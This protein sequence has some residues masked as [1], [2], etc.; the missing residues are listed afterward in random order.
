MADPPRT[1]VLRLT[2][3]SVF[4]AVG[5]L[6]LTLGV[7]A[8]LA[9]SARVIGWILAAVVIAGLLYPTVQSLSR[10]VPRGVA[11][12]LVV[13]A[14][15]ALTI[16]I[17]Y[18]VVDDVVSQ[19][20]ELQTAVPRAARKLEHSHRFGKA[21][22]EIHLA[23]RAKVF[24]DELPERLR[25]GDVQEALRSAA[26]R[27]VAFLATGVMSIFFLM[28][29]ERLLRGA[30]RQLPA[31]RQAEATRI[32]LSVYRRSWR[33]VS[34]SLTMAVAAGLLAYVCAMVLDLPGK[35][36]LAL[37]MVLLDPIPLLGVLLGA[38]PLILLAA[39]TATWQGSV[40]VAVVLVAW[41]IFE[42]VELQPKVEARSLHV[43]PFIT[44]AV[45]MIGLELYGIGG[46]I[47]GLVLAVV[48]A[49]TLDEVVGHGPHS[50][51]PSVASSG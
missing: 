39:T 7:L 1:A 4:R 5:M 43:G 25:G 36:P 32:G 46:A 47:I 18:A 33:Y 34:G 8:V 27:G 12:G 17:G 11:L 29:G 15:L 31:R 3:A 30:V 35:A 51:S 20:H 48:I 38:L 41:Q 22:R 19:M 45:A 16:G 13:F 37:W 26:T 49:A 40:A 9:A 23:K 50:A 21:A 10:R 42:A 44:I 14:S 28:Y 6:G 2:P 24:V